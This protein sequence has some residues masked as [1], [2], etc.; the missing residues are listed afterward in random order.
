MRSYRDVRESETP[1]GGHER[2]LPCFVS[3]AR[4][5]NGIRLNLVLKIY[6]R[7]YRT[8]ISGSRGGDY[9][10]VCLLRCCTV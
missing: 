2:L 3:G 6:I 4:L 9:E 5:Q 1:W 10:D 7:L 8:K